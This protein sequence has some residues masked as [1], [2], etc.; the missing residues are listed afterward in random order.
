[1]LCP[2][3]LIHMGFP[4]LLNRSGILM[5]KI[6][7]SKDYIK[8]HGQ[9]EAELLTVRRMKIDDNTPTELIEYDTTA[10]D[11]SRYDLKRGNYIQLVFLGNLGIPFCSIRLDEPILNGQ[12]EKYDF[13]SERVGH[14]FLI[15]RG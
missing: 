8:L 3:I 15:V 10:S 4:K 11:G 5:D 9:N 14:K 2:E 12:Q 1:M 6:L 7:F 13:Y